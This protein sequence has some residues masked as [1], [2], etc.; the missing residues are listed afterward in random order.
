MT[1]H[2]SL[3]LKEVSVYSKGCRLRIHPFGNGQWQ[4]TTTASSANIQ[5]IAS[6]RAAGSGR[7][8]SSMIDKLIL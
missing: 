2:L 7:L 8:N 4:S 5:E 3:L 6:I 1:L